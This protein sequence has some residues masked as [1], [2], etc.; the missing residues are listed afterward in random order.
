MTM[1][2]PM[3]PSEEARIHHISEIEGPG[4]Q[5]GAW[6]GWVTFAALVLAL[7]GCING[8][9]GFLALFDDGYFV[10]RGEELVLVNY[11]AWGAALIVWGV[12]LLL[13]G[14]GL[15]AR[16]GWARWTA[17]LVVMLDVILQ[18]GFFPSS[19]LLSVT[20]IT[21]DVI[22]LF[23]LTARWQEAKAGGI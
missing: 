16:R 3:P 13:V 10:A 9:Q 21:L 6:A 20:L 23:A 4:E 17:A 14:A 2:P 7:L 22:V 15:N 1:Q 19:P 12:A 5:G 11:D 18:V 8:F